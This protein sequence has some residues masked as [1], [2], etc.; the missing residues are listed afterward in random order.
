[1]DI[2]SKS[3]TRTVRNF[4]IKQNLVNQVREGNALTKISDSHLSPLGDRSWSNSLCS[5]YNGEIF[6]SFVGTNQDM[7]ALGLIKLTRLEYGAH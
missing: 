5:W 1:M 7:K 6:Y 4:L 3:R 2:D